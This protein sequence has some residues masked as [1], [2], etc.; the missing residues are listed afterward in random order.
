MSRSPLNPVLTGSHVYESDDAYMSR[1]EGLM[2]LY[3]AIV[4]VSNPN[5]SAWINSTPA[6]SM[7]C[8]LS[9]TTAVCG[10]AIA[11][12]VTLSAVPVTAVCC[13][14]CVPTYPGRGWRQ[15]SWG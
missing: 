1:M 7:L 12:I 11:C 6:C 10:T 9:A 14:A 4:Q 13:G 15:P 8:Y 3:G 5:K 2:I